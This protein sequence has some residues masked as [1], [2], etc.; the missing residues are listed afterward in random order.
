MFGHLP[1]ALNSTPCIKLLEAP[2][3]KNLR[4]HTK[5]PNSQ[6]QLHVAVFFFLGGGGVGDPVKGPAIAASQPAVKASR[7]VFFMFRVEVW[8]IE[9]VSVWVSFQIS[10]L[11]TGPQL[12]IK[13]SWNVLGNGYLLIMMKIIVDSSNSSRNRRR[14]NSMVG[15]SGR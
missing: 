6:N 15:G 8:E 9:A 4:L 13:A 1:P 7:G 11:R 2:N 3:E 14:R 5:L 10:E 12:Q